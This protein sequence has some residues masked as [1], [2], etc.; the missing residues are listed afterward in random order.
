L[1]V[2]AR[3]L[4]MAS[5]NRIDPI[6][7][8]AQIEL[9]R[10]RYPQIWDD[11]DTLAI[12]LEGETDLHEVLA[13]IVARICDAEEYAE[14]D[15]RLINALK[16][17][18]DRF[19]HRYEA[20]RTLA[21]KLM[22]AAGVRKVVLPQKTLSIRAGT[23]KVIITDELALPPNCVRIKREPDKVMIREL[24]DQGVPVAGAELSNSEP[25]LS[26]R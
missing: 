8:L 17:R 22:D 23:P 1:D 13:A 3:E 9:L 14:A 24:I 15:N 18:R 19:N 26:I 12:A 25:V 16:E 6:F 11:D 4:A 5:T 20:M 7:V 21:L 10:L 2:Q